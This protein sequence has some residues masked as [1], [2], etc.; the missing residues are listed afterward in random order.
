[1]IFE[2]TRNYSADMKVSLDSTNLIQ[3]EVHGVCGLIP[4]NWMNFIAKNVNI[5]V[6]KYSSPVCSNI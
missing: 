5:N 2:R 3:T 1:M 6:W 4:C